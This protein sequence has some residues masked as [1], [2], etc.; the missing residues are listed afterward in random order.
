MLLCGRTTPNGWAPCLG[1]MSL[2]ITGNLTDSLL[3]RPY[4]YVL[5]AVLPCAEAQGI[6]HGVN[7]QL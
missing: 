1:D 4:R 7:E 3:L 5:E 6:V 2:G